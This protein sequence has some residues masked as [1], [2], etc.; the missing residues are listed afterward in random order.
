M[1]WLTRRG[2]V[3]HLGFRYSG[4]IFRT[5]LKTTERRVANAAVT[6]HPALQSA[7]GVELTRFEWRRHRSLTTRPHRRHN[8][9]GARQNGTTKRRPRRIARHGQPG[10]NWTLLP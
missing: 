10:H 2:D 8:A 6:R 4:R 1:A 5:S 9:R 3:F 7:T